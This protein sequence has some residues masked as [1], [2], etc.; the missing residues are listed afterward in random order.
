MK[1]LLVLPILFF[2]F[3]LD[4]AT[5]DRFGNSRREV[6]RSSFTDSNNDLKVMISSVSKYWSDTGNRGSDTIYLRRAIISGVNPS[7][8]TFYDVFHFNNPFST[9]AKIMYNPELTGGTMM[10]SQVIDFDVPFSSGLSYSKVEATNS[11]TVFLQILWDY[12]VPPI[13]GGVG[14]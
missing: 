4:A 3:R 13:A 5:S 7:T 14:K 9:A 11:G 1:Q 12:S 6:F 2:A 10:G 8:V